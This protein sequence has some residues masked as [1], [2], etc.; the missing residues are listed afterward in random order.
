[1]AILDM[2]RIELLAMLNDSK[3]IIELIQQYG[4]VEITDYEADSDRLYK[5]ST[6]TTISQIEKQHATAKSALDVLNIYS[7]VKSSM[8]ASFAPRS[9]LTLSEYFFKAQEVDSILS[10]CYDINSLY[11]EIQDNK[12]EIVKKQTAIDMLKPWVNLDIPA[13]FNGTMFSTVFIG[14]FHDAYDRESLLSAIAQQNP[15]LNCDAEIISS[16]KSQTCVLVICHKD[17]AKELEKSLRNLDFVS[18]SDTSNSEPKKSVQMLETQIKDCTDD[19]SRCEEKIKAHAE[20]REHID[21]LLDYFVLRT[22]KYKALDK[23]SMSDNV[24]ILSGYIPEKNVDKLVNKLEEHFDVAITITNPD[25]E[26]EDV[27]VAI[28]NGKVASTMETVTNMYS[29]PNRLDI[30]PNP[31]MPFFYYMFFGLMLSDA[32]YGLV[33]II[34][35]LVIKIKY[36]LEPE[37]A[38]TVNYVLLGGMGTTFWGFMFNGWFGDLPQYLNLNYFTN[39]HIYW[40]QPL[41][42]TTEFLLFCLLLGIVHLALGYIVNMVL[43]FKRGHALDA[44]L[45][46]VPTIMILVGVLPTINS[47][48]GGDILNKGSTKFIYDFLTGPAQKTLNMVL[49]VGAVLIVLTHGRKSKGIVGKIVGGLSS[50]YNAAS[51]CLGDIL[52]YS[53]LLA[54]GLCTGVIASVVNMLAAMPGNKVAFVIILILGHTLN[55]AINLIGTYVHTNRLQYVEFFSKFY[56]GGGRLFNP[57]SVNTKTFKFKEDIKS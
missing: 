47:Q 27:P 30:D 2:K 31:I 52:S 50:L 3:T 11:K 33:M 16:D 14:S 1:M 6:S 17:D 23:L 24:F 54:L 48:I 15:E 49:L 41:K 21:F 10:K 29:P 57:L 28:E 4:V 8:L 7:P 45:D 26:N 40:F 55:M 36:K 20:D 35:A 22:D 44:I 9:E 32:G 51:G 5:L 39:H 37:K 25:F 46:N 34:A 18:Q 53:R 13:S 38:R 56:E 12:V 42:Y 43:N 19:I